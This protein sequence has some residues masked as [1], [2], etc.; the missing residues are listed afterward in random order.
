[1]VAGGGFGCLADTA[2]GLAGAVLGGLL[3][4]LLTPNRAVDTGGII[5]DVI[6]AFIGAALLLAILRLLTPRAS[7]LAAAPLSVAGRGRG[8]PRSCWCATAPPTGARRAGTPAGPT[9]RST[10]RASARRARSGP[11]LARVDV[12]RPS[13][14]STLQRAVM[15]CERAGFAR[16]A[17]L[18]PDLREW[19]YGDYEGLTTPE[20]R[21][22][23]PGWN[24]WD[25]GV[26][27]G[28]ALDDVAA[29]ADRVV[30]RLRDAAGD[31]AVF[32]HGHFLRVLAAR[33]IGERPQ[34]ARYMYLSTASVSTLTWEHDWPSISLWNDASHLRAGA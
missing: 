33:W 12:R 23:V 30:A 18:D 3:L 20:I 11:R 10:T 24:L 13:L 4:S 14:C 1:M 16:S 17:E 34:L 28:E 9:S 8:H 15:T 6:V 27:D 7:R 26:L 32:A 22:R 29:R 19:N 21:E 5:G 25:D 31:V 2:V